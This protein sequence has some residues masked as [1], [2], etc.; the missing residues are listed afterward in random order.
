MKATWIF[1]GGPVV[2]VDRE[3]RVAEAIAIDGKRI[4]AVGSKDQAMEYRGPSTEVV[5]L[6]G[7][8]LLPGLVESHCHMLSFGTNE[9]GVNLKYPNVK[10]MGELQAALRKKAAET[11]PGQWI[12]GWGYDHSKLAENRHPERWDLDAVSTVHPILV[13]RTCGHI[14]AA[15][16]LALKS[17]GLT[18]E[19][20]DPPGG[21]F[22]RRDGRLTGVAFEAAQ[23]LVRG[24]SRY[25][26][27]DLR[28]ALKAC[29][30]YW[31][32]SGFTSS[33]DAGSI[34]GR[35]E[36]L[37]DALAAGEVKLRVYMMATV[38]G[39]ASLD[40]WLTSLESG[41]R[42]RMESDRVKVG[43]LKVFIDG[44]SSGPTAATR[45]PYTSNPADSGMLYMDQE[46]LNQ[47]IEKGHAAGC[48]VTCHAVGDRAVEMM[49]NALEM[50]MANHP[51]P[52]PRHRI[53][54]CGICPPDLQERIRRLGVIPVAQPVF[55]HEFGDG[56][57]RNYGPA[58][59]RHMFPARSFLEQGIPVAAS[60]D[61]PV[62]YVDSN[63][64]LYSALTRKTMTGQVCAA[65][66]TVDIMSAI[67]MYTYNGAYAMFRENE[68]G[69]LE[70]GKLADLA[71]FSGDILRMSPPEVRHATVDMTFVDGELVYENRENQR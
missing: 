40:K 16:S 18:D 49:L 8:A 63:L 24:P 64:G 21:K 50:A 7:R 51:R 48:Q 12:R 34:A 65:E 52:D 46:R 2:T 66:E 47:L 42:E 29:N 17:A 23:G 70:P 22:G 31:L 1:T 69:S 3:D 41:F 33:A 55:F 28:K 27:D 15:N 43:P 60:S 4:L 11:P 57:L 53:E 30:D 5:D 67:R 14:V 6:K 56:Y 37:Q 10:S 68:I 20:S 44:S 59:V 71:V 25:S 9:L 39:P 19:T 13:S 61:S 58:R 45:D 26:Y 35:P 54:H 62:T 36:V 32:Q 38:D